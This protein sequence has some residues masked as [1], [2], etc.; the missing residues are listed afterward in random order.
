MKK[1]ESSINSRGTVP[2]FAP[3]LRP[4]RLIYLEWQNETVSRFRKLKII[5]TSL[6]GPELVL[7]EPNNPMKLERAYI[8]VRM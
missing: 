7:A 1:Y 3:E 8:N 4:E 2:L 6:N 5:Q